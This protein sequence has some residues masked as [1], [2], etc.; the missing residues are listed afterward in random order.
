MEHRWGHRLPVKIPVLL[1]PESG[2]PVMGETENV[3][4]SGAL[5]QI[6]RSIR[7]FARL[8]VE[9]TLPGEFGGRA[10]RVA[11]HVIRKSRHGAAIEWCDFAPRAVRALL[12]A[13][14]PLAP[15]A[16]NRETPP[17]QE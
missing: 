6:P 1:V 7:L 10:E 12:L 15:R 14:D 5:V 8:E 16:G 13:S 3:S 11:A 4:F 9:V 17:E 2:E